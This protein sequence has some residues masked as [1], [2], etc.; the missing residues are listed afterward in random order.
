VLLDRYAVLNFGKVFK[1]NPDPSK[2]E[3]KADPR[4]KYDMD[5]LKTE[6][7]PALLNKA[8]KALQDLIANGIDYSCTEKAFSEIQAENSH[9][10]RFAQE[11]GL[12]YR[13]D[14]VV[15]AKQIWQYLE[16]WY[17]DDGTLTVETDR[18]GNEQR[19]WVDQPKPS[20]KNVKGPNQVI[21]RFL[22]IFP[23]AKRADLP[24]NAA[25]IQGIGFSY[26]EPNH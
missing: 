19:V 8:I 5:F 7:C 22:E 11:V 21:K 10:Y 24:N 13:E 9:L 25:G 17:K 26:S 14:S 4:F 23:K 16:D 20:D 12:V 3:L 2:G 18:F 15:S 6:V 1:E